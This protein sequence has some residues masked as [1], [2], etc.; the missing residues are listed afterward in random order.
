MALLSQKASWRRADP[1]VARSDIGATAVSSGANIQLFTWCIRR[2]YS[3]PSLC[4]ASRQQGSSLAGQQ[5]SSTLDNP[6]SSATSLVPSPS[7]DGSPYRYAFTFGL[8]GSN[9]LSPVAILPSPRINN[10]PNNSCRDKHCTLRHQYRKV[11]STCRRRCV[12]HCRHA[13]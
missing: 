6:V 4:I 5:A 11:P 8:C 13:H 2:T 12:G 1:V 10:T 7:S 9:T 3:P